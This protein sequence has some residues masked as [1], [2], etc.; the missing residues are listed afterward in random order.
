MKSFQWFHQRHIEKSAEIKYDNINIENLRR[1]ARQGACVVGRLDRIKAAQEASKANGFNPLDLNEGNVQAIFN[2]CLATEDEKETFDK[3]FC[4]Q[5]LKPSLTNKTSDEVILSREKVEQNRLNIKF[6]FGQILNIHGDCSAIGLQEGILKY[7]DTLWTK[8]YG[9][10][11][12]LYCLAQS[13]GLIT[14]F[15]A[16][17]SDPNIISAIKASNV[18][19]TLSPKD[20]NFPAWWEAHK[21]EWEA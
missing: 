18:V 17:P 19:P 21:S 11:F 2:R 15:S 14:E 10:V 20:P 7:D 16:I 13:K 4:C 5:I 12:K 8:D 9:I 6:M 3:S 1:W